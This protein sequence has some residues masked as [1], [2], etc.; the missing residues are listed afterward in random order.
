MSGG[1]VNVPIVFVAQQM[2]APM[3]DLPTL[4]LPRILPLTLPWP[5]SNM[6]SYPNDAK[7]MMKSAI[8][9]NDPVCVMENTILYNLQGEVPQEDDVLIPLAKLG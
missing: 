2:E 7:G 1:L 6:P 5:E 9:D 3:L 4:I 8:R